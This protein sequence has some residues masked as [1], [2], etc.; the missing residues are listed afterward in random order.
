ML[1][2]RHDMLE[3]DEEEYTEHYLY[4]LTSTGVFSYHRVF[5]GLRKIYQPREPSE[6]LGALTLLCF[7]IPGVEPFCHRRIFAQWY[8]A[9]TGIPVPE[10]YYNH[11]TGKIGELEHP[12]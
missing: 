1:Y 7:C 9:W 5:E 6:A 10:L 2:P 4:I 3:M 8:E 12:F 11:T